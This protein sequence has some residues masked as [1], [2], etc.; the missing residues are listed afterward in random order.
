MKKLII[1]CC[2]PWLICLQACAQKQDKNE[3]ATEDK[4]PQYPKEKQI[5][6]IA[7]LNSK[8]PFELYLDDNLIDWELMSG[9]NK[10]V[11]LNPYLLNNGTH[12]LKIR[13]FPPESNEDKLVHPNDIVY[14]K[15]VKWHLYF[16]KLK[17]DAADPLGHAG[18]I[19]YPGSAL[20]IV[21]PPTDVP[22]WEQEFKVQVNDLP[23]TSKGWS[24]GEDLSKR[25]QKELEKVAVS[26]FNKLRNLLNEGKIKEFMAL[27]KTNDFE[28]SVSNYDNQ[29]QYE[30]DYL[31][32][33]ELLTKKC[34][35]NMQ[36]INNYIMKL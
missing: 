16:V 9:I 1:Y 4:L 28:T 3:L 29:K 5:S 23:Y 24:D 6:F 31:E 30:D 13:F 12:I 17:K 20:P 7:H 22:I 34:V 35:G 25:D 19:D 2:L 36:P 18:E 15:D 8:T 32:N 14:D 21:A 10:S 11:E 27:N 33:V 26:Y